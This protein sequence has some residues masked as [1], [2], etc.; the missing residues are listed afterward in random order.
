MIDK[1]SGAIMPPVIVRDKEDRHTLNVKIDVED[2][3]IILNSMTDSCGCQ[4]CRELVHKLKVALSQS[5]REEV[6]A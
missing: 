6:Q 3:Y 2:F 5:N 1:I 4:E